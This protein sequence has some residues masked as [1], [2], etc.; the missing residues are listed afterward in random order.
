VVASKE[1]VNPSEI[2]EYPDVIGYDYRKALTGKSGREV[3]AVTLDGHGH[4]GRVKSVRTVANP[5]AAA[6]S[7]EGKYLAEGVEKQWDVLFLQMLGQNLREPQ[8]DDARQPKLQS[9]S[10]SFPPLAVPFR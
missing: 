5:A 3:V 8:R 2:I 6:P 10:G 4:R 1:A 9:V 7:P